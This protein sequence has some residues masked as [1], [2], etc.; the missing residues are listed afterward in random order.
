MKAW[1]SSR[2]RALVLS[3][4]RAADTDLTMVE[5]HYRIPGS[6]PRLEAIR[7]AMIDLHGVGA[8]TRVGRDASGIRWALANPDVPRVGLPRVVPGPCPFVF[9]RAHTLVTTHLADPTGQVIAGWWDDCNTMS[10]Q[11]AD[12]HD[13]DH[14]PPA[15]YERVR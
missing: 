13:G 15:P 8:V 1:P 7:L 2:V 3:V 5:I 6:R 4:L 10:C 11:L 14:R 12:G 9:V